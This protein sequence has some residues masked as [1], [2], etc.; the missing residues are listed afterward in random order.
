MFKLEIREIDGVAA[1]VLPPEI[2]NRLDAHPG[3]TL[4]AV[5]TPIGYL[6]T[7]KN[8]EIAKQIEAGEV[9]M[10]QYKDVFTALAK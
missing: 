8:P 4:Y 6:L 3:E 1:L 2:L 7:E 5:E 9:L 10:D